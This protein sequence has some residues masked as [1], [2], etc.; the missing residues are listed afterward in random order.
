[1]V[2]YAVLILI[3]YEGTILMKLWAWVVHTRITLQKELAEIRLLLAEL[4]EARRTEA[5][6]PS[7]D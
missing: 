7:G 2:G 1:M 3:M 5:V 4:M 6:P